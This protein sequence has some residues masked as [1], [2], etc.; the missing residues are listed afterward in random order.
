MAGDIILLTINCLCL[1]LSLSSI[2]SVILFLFVILH[3]YSS[4]LYHHIDWFDQRQRKNSLRTRSRCI[5]T[6]P[7]VHL[8]QKVRMYVNSATSTIMIIYS[9][10]GYTSLFFFSFLQLWIFSYLHCN[11]INVMLCCSGSTYL[12]KRGREG[13]SDHSRSSKGGPRRGVIRK[14]MVK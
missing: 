8:D 1:C 14:I 7:H 4:S 10:L 5:Q 13:A 6:F 12:G 9:S 2:P 3:P 11:V